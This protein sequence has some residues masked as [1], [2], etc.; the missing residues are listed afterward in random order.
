MGPGLAEDPLITLLQ[1]QERRS[2]RATLTNHRSGDPWPVPSSNGEDRRPARRQRLHLRK[3]PDV[4]AAK[5]SGTKLLKVV[6]RPREH[7]LTRL[8]RLCSLPAPSYRPTHVWKR[9]HDQYRELT[10]ESGDQAPTSSPAEYRALM[11]YAR[12]E[13]WQRFGD[14]FADDRALRCT[15]TASGMI[16]RLEDRS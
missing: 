13:S 9:L 15:Q 12:S 1:P 7:D 14:Q 16:D 2:S 11:R 4:R 5:G 3:V 10:L 8:P 6:R